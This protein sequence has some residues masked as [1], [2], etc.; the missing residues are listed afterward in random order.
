MKNNRTIILIIS[1]VIIF[2]IIPRGIFCYAAEEETTEK[3]STITLTRKDDD[4]EILKEEKPYEYQKDYILTS[5]MEFPEPGECYGR[6][7]C[8]R[9]G[10]DVAAYWTDTDDQLDIGAGTSTAGL[11]PGF[12][13]PVII[14]GH[15]LTHFSCLQYLEVGD[16]ISF[17]TT[18]GPYEYEVTDIQVYNENDLLD[19]LIEKTGYKEYPE[20]DE[21]AAEE[22]LTEAEDP[23]EELI[24]YTCYPFYAISERKTN[25]YTVIAR[26]IS[27]M[28]VVSRYYVDSMR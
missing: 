19:L 13:K 11:I 26:R 5:D 8:D 20:E 10:M 22:D 3:K 9:I 24:L 2:L 21:T 16:I 14:S 18:Y 12:Q 15:T 25:R 23:T 1:I 28:D 7:I 6:I 4:K 27:G 17:D